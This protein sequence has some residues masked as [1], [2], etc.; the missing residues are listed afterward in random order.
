MSSTFTLNKFANTTR[1]SIAGRVTPCCHLYIAWGVAKPKIS[2]YSRTESPDF[3]R[4]SVILFPVLII[5]IVGIL[6]ILFFSE[7][8]KNRYKK[9]TYPYTDKWS[10]SYVH[11]LLPWKI[12]GSTISAYRHATSFL[13][14]MRTGKYDSDLFQNPA[15]LVSHHYG[16]L[17]LLLWSSL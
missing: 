15:P 8:I 5:F 13:S 14:C 1:L 3:F 17:V 4:N 7:F 10:K 12:Y 11:I 16:Y 6:L 2:C 9:T